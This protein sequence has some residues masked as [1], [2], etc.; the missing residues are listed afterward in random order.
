MKRIVS[1]TVEFGKAKGREMAGAILQDVATKLGLE[2]TFGLLKDF[3]KVYGGQN[4]HY[5]C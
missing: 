3:L 1:A 4:L 2:N 5:A